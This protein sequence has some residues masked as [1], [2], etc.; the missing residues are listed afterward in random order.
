MGKSG[1]WVVRLLVA[2][3][4]SLVLYWVF[5]FVTVALGPRM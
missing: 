1:K 5:L 4:V 3:A 2:V